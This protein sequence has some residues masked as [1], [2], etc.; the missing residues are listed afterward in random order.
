MRKIEPFSPHKTGN[1]FM[2]TNSCS[3]INSPTRILIVEDNPDD[4]LLL[5]RQL[6]KADLDTQVRVITDGGR[7]LD[8][9]T[10]QRYRPEDLVAIFLDLQLPT[11]NGLQLLQAI[12]SDD[13]IK[14]LPV[15]L[16]TSSNAPEQVDQC[17]ELGISSFVQKPVTFSAFVKAVADSFHGYRPASLHLVTVE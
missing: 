13:R 2:R 7:A 4:E 10:D 1:S 16:T 9:L 6:K 14:H 15:V 17:R 12:R 5:L 11:L 3:T 8:Y